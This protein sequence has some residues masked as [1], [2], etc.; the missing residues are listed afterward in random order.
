MTSSS[1]STTKK[2][3]KG[4]T[5]VANPNSTGGKGFLWALLAQVLV[6]ALVIGL[7]V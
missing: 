2:S 6:G 5:K 7:N 3:A 1:K 4:S